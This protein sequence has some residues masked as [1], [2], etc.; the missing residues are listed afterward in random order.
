MKGHRP[1]RVAE[2]L[3]E[4]IG[5]ILSYEINDE[6]IGP[7]NVTRIKLSPDLRHARVLVDFP[8]NDRNVEKAVAALNHASG[9]VR[10]ELLSRVQLRLVPQLD[11]AYDD[12]K[13]RADRIERI[14]KEVL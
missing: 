14:L 8:G 5:D 1:D 10:S 11:F 13:A 3:R 12:A 7:V 6:R 9:F 2:L 4:E